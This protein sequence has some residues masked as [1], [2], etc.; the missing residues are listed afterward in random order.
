[1]D[2]IEGDFFSIERFKFNEI[3]FRFEFCQ[4]SIFS[5]LQHQLKV[6]YEKKNNN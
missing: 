1:M 3:L 6:A 2:Y 4:F 5:L